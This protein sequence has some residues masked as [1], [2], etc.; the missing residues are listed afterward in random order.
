M[1]PKLINEQRAALRQDTDRE[2]IRQGI[3]D[4]EAGRVVT[5]EGL[6]ASIQ[7]KMRRP[8]SA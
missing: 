7:A 4:M 2:A 3:A 6:D 1:T 5:P 8:Q